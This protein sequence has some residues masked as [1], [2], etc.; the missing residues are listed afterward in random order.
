MELCGYR[1]DEMISKYELKKLDLKWLPKEGRM[2][3]KELY[4]DKLENIG[5]KKSSPDISEVT[6]M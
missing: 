1:Y 4:R 3:V 2:L 6:Y 5:P